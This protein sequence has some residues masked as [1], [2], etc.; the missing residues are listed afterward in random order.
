MESSSKRNKIQVCELTKSLLMAVAGQS[1]ELRERRDIKDQT[2]AYLKGKGWRE[3]WW[4]SGTSSPTCG[5]AHKPSKACDKHD[6]E[7]QAAVPL[8]LDLARP[9]DTTSGPIKAPNKQH[10][11][12]LGQDLFDAAHHGLVE[13]VI[14]L[15]EYRLLD[16][17]SSRE[18]AN[19]ILTKGVREELRALV[20]EILSMY[21]DV[22]FH[23][24]K[25][26]CHVTVSMNKLLEITASTRSEMSIP[27]WYWSDEM[28]CFAMV[29]AALIHDV[30][31]LGMPNKILV[32]LGH[33][34]AHKYENKSVA[35]SNSIDIATDL[36]L[37]GDYPHLRA[38]L[39]KSQDEMNAF[40]MLIRVAVSSTDIA[41]K[42][43]M[44][45]CKELLECAFGLKEGVDQAEIK[46][47][48]EYHAFNLSMLNN[49]DATQL[50]AT[51]LCQNCAFL[52]LLV[53][54]ADVA[55]TMQ[56]FEMFIRWNYRLYK[57]QQA[58][59]ASY[60]LPTNP[61]DNWPTSNIGFF[62]FYVEPLA[63][64]LC[65]LSSSDLD[66]LSMLSKY[67]KQNRDRW[68][69]YGEQITELMVRGV[70]SGEDEDKTIESILRVCYSYSER[71]KP[72]VTVR[73]RAA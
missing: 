34:L 27:G 15:L 59:H 13:V 47:L 19:G 73:N 36:L 57:E 61:S 60:L 69:K 38:S 30:G 68:S 54:A 37:N 9:G 3:T 65:H 43:N 10:W 50:D 32:D 70:E 55:H 6:A 62:D 41:C 66:E 11:S 21:N 52:Q 40:I 49:L 63:A 23:N 45:E 44:G 20:F 56:P 46:D 8:E 39:F 2:G 35:E 22:N 28:V 14:N 42:D 67:T 71:Q 26:S 17:E 12:L 33:D 72:W 53:Q 48:Q 5:C 16:L 24:F 7:I 29:F 64:R 4:L 31:H 51:L 1:F 18:G 58:L 25:H